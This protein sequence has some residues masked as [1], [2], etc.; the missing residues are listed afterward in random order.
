MV[1]LIEACTC[2]RVRFH[3]ASGDLFGG[4]KDCFARLHTLLCHSFRAGVCV[5]KCACVCE[6]SPSLSPR[7]VPSV[8]T[9]PLTFNRPCLLIIR[10]AW[11][12]LRH[13]NRPFADKTPRL[14]KGGNQRL[15]H[16]NSL[17]QILQ[18]QSFCRHQGRSIKP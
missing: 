7:H 10:S 5:Y 1:Y 6:A 18:S 8:P 9:G 14:K 13:F 2:H 16:R 17:I 4:Q 15:R 11:N 12:S 3:P